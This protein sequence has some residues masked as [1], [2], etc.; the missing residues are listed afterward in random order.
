MRGRFAQGTLERL[1]GAALVVCMNMQ[2]GNAGGFREC[3]HVQVGVPQIWCFAVL[4]GCS[5][6]PLPPPPRPP[7]PP[8]LPPSHPKPPH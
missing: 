3:V 5:A 2:S 6:R 4:L 1:L 7:L 8:S